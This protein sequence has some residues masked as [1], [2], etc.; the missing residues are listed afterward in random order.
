MKLL[1]L[2][3]LIFIITGIVSLQIIRTVPVIPLGG[4][5]AGGPFPVIGFRTYIY[6]HKNDVLDLKYRLVGERKWNI[7]IIVKRVATGEAWFYNDL[8]HVEEPITPIF[9]APYTG[10][11]HLSIEVRG[12][13]E[14]PPS[15]KCELSVTPS[16]IGFRYEYWLPRLLTLILIGLILIILGLWLKINVPKFLTIVAK[17]IYDLWKIYIALAFT[18]V[19]LYIRVFPYAYRDGWNLFKEII[20]MPIHKD[21]YLATVIYESTFRPLIEAGLMYANG[22]L[23][24]VY[25]S[26][27]S[28]AL[29]SY[30]F[31]RKL[32]RDVTIIGVS[33]VKL[34]LSKVTAL[35]ILLFLPLAIPHIALMAL[36]DTTLLYLKPL[37][38]LR[39]I[40]IRLL[41]DIAVVLITFS[42]VLIPALTIHRTFLALAVTLLIPYILPIIG[43]E[44]TLDMLNGLISY[45]YFSYEKV[46]NQLP[47]LLT[48]PA[49]LTA[50]GVIYVKVKDLA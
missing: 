3:G 41:V 17:E 10:L 35:L 31:E 23:F 13:N 44:F 47:S 46:L 18:Y 22:V 30:C 38:V 49:V 36:A 15:L 14:R 9:K 5:S 50:I 24:Y 2:V 6:L 20:G 29:F 11:Y 39:A 25:A 8:G 21:Y 45:L 28:I 19:M 16:G 4:E 27:I 1:T 43:V 32:F 26:I 48:V 33:K 40:S 37:L 7:T 12:L 42:A 34:Y